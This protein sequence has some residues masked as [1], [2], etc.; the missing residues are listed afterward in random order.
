MVLNSLA[1]FCLIGNQGATEPLEK[2]RDVEYLARN[3]ALAQEY[4]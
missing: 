4:L 2:D 1:Q 3:P